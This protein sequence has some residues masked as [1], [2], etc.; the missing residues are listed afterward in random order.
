MGFRFQ[1]Y[2]IKHDRH[3]ENLIGVDPVAVCM[4]LQSLLSFK[5]NSDD[6]ALSADT[7]TSLGCPLGIYYD[8]STKPITMLSRRLTEDEILQRHR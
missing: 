2:A 5:V 7:I 6:N 1:K 4:M 3:R 8:Q